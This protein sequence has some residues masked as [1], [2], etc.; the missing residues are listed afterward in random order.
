MSLAFLAVLARRSSRA[1]PTAP[2]RC[3]EAEACFGF[4]Q[5]AT[6]LAATAA[7][8]IAFRCPILRRFITQMTADV[9]EARLGARVAWRGR[10]SFDVRRSTNANP[11]RVRIIQLKER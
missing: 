9:K 11:M 6:T 3:A 2:Q 4:A 8:R 10:W 7:S 1:A 5:R